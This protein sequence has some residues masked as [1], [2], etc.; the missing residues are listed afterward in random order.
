[1]QSFEVQALAGHVWYQERIDGAGDLA[2]ACAIILRTGL[3][4]ADED[5]PVWFPPHEIKAVKL[6]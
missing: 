1:M 2:S 6:L 4:T 3:M 5:G